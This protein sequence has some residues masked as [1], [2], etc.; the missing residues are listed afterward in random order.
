M[1]S[2]LT[3]SRTLRL[4]SAAP[5]AGEAL[6]RAEQALRM[7]VEV[8]RRDTSPSAPCARRHERR[9]RPVVEDA[10]RRHAGRLAAARADLGRAR[11]ALLAGLDRRATSAS[12][13]LPGVPRVRRR[14]AEA[15]AAPFPRAV[16]GERGV[17]RRLLRRQR[18]AEDQAGEQEDRPA[19]EIR[20]Q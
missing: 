4:S 5:S 13:A 14:L 15:L 11:R 6:G 3:I 16:A 2:A 1:L 7:A 12:H 20:H 10:R 8:D 19:N 17:L 9:L 18:D